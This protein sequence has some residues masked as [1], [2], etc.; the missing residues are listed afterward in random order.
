MLVR[1]EGLLSRSL[2][3]SS[4]GRDQVAQFHDITGV[5]PVLLPTTR[6]G[7]RL[8]SHHMRRSTSKER[9]MHHANDNGTSFQNPWM[10]PKGLLASGQ[11]L[12]QFPLAFERELQAHHVTPV[13]VVEPDFGGPV[14]RSDALKATW[15]GH[16][17][18]RACEYR[19]HSSLRFY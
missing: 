18:R 10:K 2:E 9:P 5:L 13:R 19:F 15:L 8:T 17:V 3:S 11:V 4:R 1:N 6:T 12:T 16:A 14:A 7:L